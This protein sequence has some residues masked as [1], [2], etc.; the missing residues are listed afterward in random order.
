MDELH[1]LANALLEH[2]TLTGEEIKALLS[3]KPIDKPKLNDSSDSGEGT[4]KKKRK[5]SSFDTPTDD[6]GENVVEVNQ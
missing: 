5:G 1:L 3:G 6:S 4:K 2:E